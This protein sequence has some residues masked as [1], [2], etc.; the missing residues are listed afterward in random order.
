VRH[1][2]RIHWFTP[3]HG[4][5]KK[6]LPP[7]KLSADARLRPAI[8]LATDAFGPTSAP[9]VTG[10]GTCTFNAQSTPDGMNYVQ[11][12]DDLFGDVLSCV[13]NNGGNVEGNSFFPYGTCTNGAPQSVSQSPTEYATFTDGEW[14]L[15]CTVPDDN[16]GGTSQANNE[17]APYTVYQQGFGCESAIGVGSDDNTPSVARGNDSLEYSQTYAENGQSVTALTT[18]CVG[19]L[20]NSVTVDTNGPVAHLVSCTQYDPKSPGDVVRGLGE[21]ITYPDGQ[22]E[23][24]C[25][26]PAYRQEVA[27]VP[28][29]NCSTDATA[30]STSE[31][32]ITEDPATPGTLTENVDQGSPLSC[33]ARQYGGYTGFDPN[34]YTWSFT[35]TGSKQLTYDL[36]NQQPDLNSVEVCFGATVPFRTISDDG[37]SQPGTLPDGT[38]G[39]IGLLP[40]CPENVNTSTDPCVESRGYIEDDFADTEVDVFIPQSFPADPATHI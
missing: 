19:Q 3:T 36:I 30:D 7:I 22:Y 24:T 26:V 35:G 25:N 4:L 16:G 6:H 32:Q 8:H 20:P 29:M 21:T 18:S 31:L 28:T 11:S 27:C 38:S 12:Y 9:N 34:W 23:E 10:T 39:Y 17:G 40:D 37:T 33:A 1:G 14:M 2:H 13:G 5:A 15:L